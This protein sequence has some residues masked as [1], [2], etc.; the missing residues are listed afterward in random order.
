VRR[1]IGEVRHRGGVHARGG[2]DHNAHCLRVVMRL[3]SPYC[4]HDGL[5][6]T[7]EMLEGLAKHN[8]PVLSPTWALAELDAAYPLE[9]QSW[10]SLEA[11]V[12]AISDDIAYDNHD[13]DDGLRAGFLTL[14]ELLEQ[15]FVAAEW[16]QVEAKFPGAPRERQL[17]ELVRS[18][19]GFMVN[20]V[21]EETKHRTQGMASVADV[22]AAGAISATF[23]QGLEAEERKL[24]RFMYDKLYYHPHQIATAEKAR[25]V[26]GELFSALAQ[27]PELM[28]DG[29]RDTLPAQEP[30]RSRHIADYI[31]GRTD[32]YAI[33]SYARIFGRR[34]DGLTNV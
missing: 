28:N 11:Q 7:W 32:R 16:R 9:L 30:E 22:R 6:L 8:G 17:R 34:P 33:D 1:R 21:I 5:N 19:I 31:A 27:Q 15:P 3:E 4:E 24:K 13:I 23:S 12:A 25:A 2:F 14:D 10:P 18:Q 26:T 29:W 20:D